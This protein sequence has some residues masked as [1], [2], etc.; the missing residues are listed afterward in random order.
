MQS[1]IGVVLICAAVLALIAVRPKASG[2]GPRFMSL[3]G[4]DEVV[5]LVLTVALG[6]GILM[7][8]ASFTSLY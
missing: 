2:V 1:V 4:V 3:A 7:T 6:F 8:S 5:A